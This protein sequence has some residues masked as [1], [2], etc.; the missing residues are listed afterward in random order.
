MLTQKQ[1]LNECL[2]SALYVA[3]KARGN[4]LGIIDNQNV[5]RAQIVDDIIRCDRMILIG[6]LLEELGNIKCFQ[7]LLF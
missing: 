3:V 4:N 5:T 6:I 7:F 2:G 1:K